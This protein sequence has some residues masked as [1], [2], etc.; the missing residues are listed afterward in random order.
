MSIGWMPPGRISNTPFQ[1][2]PCFVASVVV[3]ADARFTRMPP[4]QAKAA[5]RRMVPA[6]TAERTRLPIVQSGNLMGQQAEAELAKAALAGNALLQP[7]GP[8]RRVKDKITCHDVALSR[9]FDRT[10]IVPP[11]L[12]CNAQ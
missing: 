5:F 10:D 11:Y 3:H 4:T 1:A 9:C 12:C 7:L 2:E 6:M 8:G